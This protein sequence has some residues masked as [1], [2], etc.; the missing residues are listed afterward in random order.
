MA[1]PAWNVAHLAPLQH[2]IFID[3]IFEDFVERC[4]HMD[5]AVGVGRAIVEDKGRTW[6]RDRE[7]P[8]NIAFVPG[9]LNLWLSLCGVCP[10]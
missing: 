7:L 8:I 10:H 9:R 5:I 3:D 4:A 1:I 2:L 6:V